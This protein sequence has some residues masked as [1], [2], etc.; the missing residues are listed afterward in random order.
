MIAAIQNVSASS[1]P[2]VSSALP[3]GERFSQ[4][5][6]DAASAPST[7][8]VIVSLGAV[9]R[10]PLTYNAD[11]LLETQATAG[12]AATFI[13]GAPGTS[14]IAA[15]TVAPIATGPA[16][17]TTN[18]ALS[19]V[20]S[21][22]GILTLTPATDGSESAIAFVPTPAGAIAV[23]VPAPPAAGADPAITFIS[24]PSGAVAIV[25]PTLPIAASPSAADAAGTLIPTPPGAIAFAPVAGTTPPTAGADP[26]S[27]FI[28]APAGAIAVASPEPVV[29]AP[30]R[31]GATDTAGTDSALV[32]NAATAATPTLRFA[33]AAATV[34]ADTEA[35]VTQAEPDTTTVTTPALSP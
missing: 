1:L 9:S 19:F 25:A 14:D 30:P 2:F 11:G 15:P 12:T 33:T 3:T 32:L 35:L 7:P 16:A 34:A 5:A 8:S 22:P 28:P 26:P 24:T 18:D 6:E 4:L 31:A 17:A 10:A 20:A 23:A 27:A 13:P 29:V 21:A